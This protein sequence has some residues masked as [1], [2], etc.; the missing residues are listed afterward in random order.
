MH[1]QIAG[2][3]TGRV[4]KWIVLVAVLGITGIMA[5]FSTQLADVQN[6]EASSWLPDVGRVDH[7][8]SRSCPR[9]S[10]PTTSPPSWST[11]ARAG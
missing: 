1:R 5:G 8:C 2:A 11:T 10:T 9:P 6:N 7:G 4:T 3:L